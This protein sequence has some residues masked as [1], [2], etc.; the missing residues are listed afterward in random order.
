MYLDYSAL[1]ALAPQI[2]L[3]AL[4][5]KEQRRRGTPLFVALVLAVL[6]Y[7]PWI[8]QAI[9]SMETEGTT[10][11]GYLSLT[12]DRFFAA[13]SALIGLQDQ[14]DYFQRDLAAV[15]QMWEPLHVAMVAA[16]VVAV[17]VAVLVGWR[18]SRQAVLVAALL[19]FGTIACATLASLVSP[20]F[21]AR[22]AIAAVLGWAMLI[23]LLLAGSISARWRWIGGAVLLAICVVSAVSLYAA[24]DE[25]SLQRGPRWPELSA[26]ISK[27][28][29]ENPDFRIIVP[30]KVDYVLIDVYKSG[31]LDGKAITA[32]DE[33]AKLPQDKGDV[34]MA[35]HH[36]PT[37]APYFDELARLGY[38]R[39]SQ[40]KYSP[41]ALLLEEYKL[42]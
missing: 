38:V 30:S 17:V 24:N 34:W 6:V 1:F 4:V 32:L 39:V 14:G 7:L 18:R 15:W 5:A 40:T 41:G 3:L 20:S 19:G 23:G 26:D 27:T 11:A 29:E 21:A 2:V 10:R 28:R 9:M 8:P 37:F 33:V 31:V 42:P 25:F 36:S 16:A 35:Y 12:A 22:T 13:T